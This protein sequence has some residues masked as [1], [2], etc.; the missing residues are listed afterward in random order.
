MSSAFEEA[1][2]VR[3][4]HAL[5]PLKYDYTFP[6]QGQAFQH[7]KMEAVGS[8]DGSDRCRQVLL[9][10][11][12]LIESWNEARATESYAIVSRARVIVGGID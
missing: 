12:P 1:I 3:L 9:C 6:A 8:M 7:E 2:R 10:L 11:S 4:K 5:S